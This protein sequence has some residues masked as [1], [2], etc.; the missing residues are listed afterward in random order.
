MHK[1]EILANVE[2]GWPGLTKAKRLGKGKSS[3]LGDYASTD[4]W[5]TSSLPWF[6]AHLRWMAIRRPPNWDFK[7]CSDVDLMRA[8][9]GSVPLSGREIIDPDIAAQVSMR[10]LTLLDLIEPPGLLIIRLG[11]KTARNEATPEV[12]LETLYHRMHLGKPTWVYNDHHNPLDDTMR[13]YSEEV[14]VL[15]SDWKRVVR[16][17]PA[18]MRHHTPEVLEEDDDGVEDINPGST[19]PAPTPT[20]RAR[21]TLS[22]GT[23]SAKATKQPVKEDPKK[24]NWKKGPKR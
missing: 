14:G 9:L 8:W 5:V 4:L 20:S 13:A 10:H 22:S 2:R 18:P 19:P 11:V 16:G 7:V 23:G 24:K 15:L 12:L 6:K 21:R 3:K 1:K 17:A